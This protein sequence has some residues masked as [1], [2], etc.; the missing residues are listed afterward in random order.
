LVRVFGPSGADSHDGGRHP[1]RPERIDAVMA[2]VDALALILGS[3]LAIHPAERAS[4]DQLLAVHDA[5]YVDRVEQ[6]CASGGGQIDPDTFLRPDSWDTALRSA[7]AGPQAVAALRSAGSGAAFIATRPPGHHALAHQ[8]MGF[9]V[10]NNVAVTA[11]L[12]AAEGERVVIVDWDVHHGNGTQ[13]LFWNDPRVLYVSTHQSPWYPG[14][15]AAED[16]GGSA[17]PGLTVNVPLPAGATGD[18]VQRA[19]GEVAESVIDAFDPTWVL[20]SAGFD[21]HRDDPLSDLA[22]SGADFAA[23]ARQVSSYA[24]ADGRLVLFLEGGYSLNGL[25][26]SVEC[27]LGALAGAN[28]ATTAEAPTTGGQGAE[29]VS[30]AV[31]I[32]ERAIGRLTD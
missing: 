27:T 14:T 15:G 18:V 6:M 10:F 13:D 29:A 9:C 16:V 24:P 23:L 17:A 31:V 30:N 26:N 28:V 7:G 4:R 21:A 2:G 11:A 3:D 25:R 32:R 1:E 22:L 8:G 20:V 5:D 12:L 19:L